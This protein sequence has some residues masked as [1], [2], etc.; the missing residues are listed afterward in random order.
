M[1]DFTYEDINKLIKGLVT[2]KLSVQYSNYGTEKG[3]IEQI[4]KIDAVHDSLKKL[5]KKLEF[6][7]DPFTW[8]YGYERRQQLKNKL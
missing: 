6:K 5:R 1:E 4:K 3:R 8:D 7:D 2:G